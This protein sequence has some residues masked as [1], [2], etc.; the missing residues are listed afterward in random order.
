M[1]GTLEWRSV[2]RLCPGPGGP[3]ATSAI[4]SAS[5]VL[6][7]LRTCPHLGRGPCK[8]PSG[9]KTREQGQ[10]LTGNLLSCI[11]KGSSQKWKIHFRF[12]FFSQQQKKKAYLF[13]MTAPAIFKSA[14][15][16]TLQLFFFF[17]VECF[18]DKP[19][20]REGQFKEFS[21]LPSSQL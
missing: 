21:W 7:S 9:Q 11:S 10:A 20:Q 2:T 6:Q 19:F 13:E 14:I 5:K 17:L 16:P 8:E 1:E 15:F 4:A 18:Q 3:V 12:Y